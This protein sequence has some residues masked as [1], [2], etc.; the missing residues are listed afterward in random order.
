MVFRRALI[1]SRHRANR[2][3]DL[4]LNIPCMFNTSP[5]Q[6]DIFPE[7]YLAEVILNITNRSLW[8]VIIQIYESIRG[9]TL[10]HSFESEII[11]EVEIKTLYF[12]LLCARDNNLHTQCF[13]VGREL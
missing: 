3:R 9:H 11:F 12:V 6:S 13:L 8:Q 1:I 10:G 5:M 4:L 7:N 2:F